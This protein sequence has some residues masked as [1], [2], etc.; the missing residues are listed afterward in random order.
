MPFS[1]ADLVA[2]Y[3]LTPERGEELSVAIRAGQNY[4]AISREFFPDVD[5]ESCGRHRI[6]RLRA[7]LTFSDPPP[8]EVA[9]EKD[10]AVAKLTQQLKDKDSK[11]QFVLGQLEKAQQE[12]SA[13]SLLRGVQ[14]PPSLIPQPSSGS[15]GSV[16]VFCFGDWHVEE[17][18]NPATVNGMN[19]FNPE[20]AKART[21]KLA[22]Q[23]VDLTKMFARDTKIDRGIICL[24]GDFIT[25]STHPHAEGVCMSPN[26]AVVFATERLMEVLSY[27]SDHSPMSTIHVVCKSGNHGRM[28][29]D[30]KISTEA[31]HSLEHTMYRFLAL[32]YKDHPAL[33]FHI[34][35]GYHSYVP[36]FNTVLRIHHGHH[37]RYWGGVGGLTI[38]VLKKI[39]CWN[40]VGPA[41]VDLFGH[42]HTF[43]PHRKFRCN[44]SLIGLSPY[45]LSV[46][47]EY[48]M[49]TQDM[50]LIHERLGVTIQSPIYLEDPIHAKSFAFLAA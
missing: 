1:F 27:I 21:A 41:D 18:I 44:G 7:A 16:A 48:E 32:R 13:V 2:G 23:A 11:Y 35:D 36:V 49:P 6:P 30:Q 45:G 8:T 40:A 9:V 33:Q 24:L 4:R 38:P 10:R 28:T 26:D 42:F 5:A 15:S 47:G 12:L 39:A 20:I 37:L 25:N 43:T 17:V 46:G 31:G 22:R 14:D 29:K 3:G 34:E 19:E 50:F